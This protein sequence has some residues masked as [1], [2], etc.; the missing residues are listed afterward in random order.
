MSGRPGVLRE[1]NVVADDFRDH[2]QIVVRLTADDGPSADVAGGVSGEVLSFTTG[3]RQRWWCWHHQV[4][5][6]AAA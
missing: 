1:D 2:S 6:G 3:A 5:S 4:C